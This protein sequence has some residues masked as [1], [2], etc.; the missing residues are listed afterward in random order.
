M[1]ICIK[2]VLIACLLEI[3]LFA[4]LFVAETRKPHYLKPVDTVLGWYHLFSF[5]FGYAVVT[6]SGPRQG[7]TTASNAAYW[8]SIFACQ[9][10]LTTPIVF[11]VFKVDPPL[12]VTC[13]VSVKQMMDRECKAQ[14]RSVER[15]ELNDRR[16]KACA[17]N[18]NTED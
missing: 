13:A 6:L 12:L 18:G 2:A 3:P 15:F 5:L 14:Q 8:I 7:P 10:G 11:V 17:T 9:V 16:P 4:T 1:K